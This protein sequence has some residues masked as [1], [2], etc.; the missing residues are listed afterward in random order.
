MFDELLNETTQVV[1][2][3]F[4]V[5]AA[6]ATDKRQQQNTTQSTTTTVVADIPLLNIQTTPKTTSQAP[7]VTATENINQIET[8]K[9]NAQ[10]EEYKFINIFST[11]IQERWETSFRLP[12]SSNM[13]TFYQRRPSEHHG[14]MCMFAL[15]VSRTEPKNIKEVMADSAWIEAMKEEL[16]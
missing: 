8:N 10:V 11:P 5:N 1:S 15:T 9:E 13:H 16:H 4:A 7:T 12:D 3:S 6:D 14:E 2:K